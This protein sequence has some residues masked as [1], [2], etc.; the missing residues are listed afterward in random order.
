MIVRIC[1]VCLALLLLFSV[2]AAQSYYSPLNSAALK[3]RN[4]G[5]D[6]DVKNGGEEYY[7]FESSNPCTDCC[8]RCYM[9]HFQTTVVDGG[10]TYPGFCSEEGENCEVFA[11]IRTR[12]CSRCCED[13]SH[14]YSLSESCDGDQLER[15]HSTVSTCEIGRFDV[16]VGPDHV[17][18]HDMFFGP[19]CTHN[20][21]FDMQAYEDECEQIELKDCVESNVGSLF[22]WVFN[23]NANYNGWPNDCFWDKHFRTEHMSSC[24]NTNSRFTAWCPPTGPSTAWLRNDLKNSE[25]IPMNCEAMAERRDELCTDFSP[26]A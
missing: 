5:T 10:C 13:G 19:D 8:Q 26:P 21:S 17:R 24:D 1:S 9:A 15:L 25:L 4:F 12:P 20:P 22:R 16:C 6:L 14:V 23:D 11:F 2:C 3:C 7:S 18:M